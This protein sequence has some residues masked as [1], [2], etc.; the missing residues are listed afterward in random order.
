MVFAPALF[1]CFVQ[2]ISFVLRLPAIASVMFDRLGQVVFRMR[3]APLALLVDFIPGFSKGP[4]YRG[5][6]DQPRPIPKDN[7][8]NPAAP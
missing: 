3:N 7:I 2:L 1:P 5:R 8:H 4:R 6:S